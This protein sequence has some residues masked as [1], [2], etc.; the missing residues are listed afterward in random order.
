[1]IVDF[2]LSNFRSI[3][4]PMTLSMCATNIK[5]HEKNVIH[6]KREPKLGMLRSSVL[7]GPNASGKSNLIKALDV[8][9][10]FV[11]ESTDLKLDQKIPY[12]QPF[13][14]DKKWRGKP[15]DFEI[16]FIGYDGIRYRYSITF[17]NIEV[18][19]E[20]LVFFPKG[21]EANLFLRQKN[22]EIKFGDYF[23]GPKKSIEK[24]LLKN[25]LFLSKAAN[26]NNDQMKHIYTYF[27]DSLII[28]R[29]HHVPSVFPCFTTEACV[30][31]ESS[32]SL[33]MIGKF[34]KIADTGIEFME[35]DTES[36]S[37]DKLKLP[38]SMPEELKKAIILSFEN[39]PKMHHILFD[40]SQNSGTIGF[41]LDEESDGT[42]KLYRLSGEILYSL[43]NGLVLIIDELGSSLHPHM[44]RSIIELFNDPSI[45]FNNAQLIFASHD[46]TLLNPDIFRRDQIWMTEKNEFGATSLYSLVE[47]DPKKVRANI[48]FDK[49]YLSGRFGALPVIGELGEWIA[50][51]QKKANIQEKS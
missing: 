6:T 33:E 42:V 47:F 21:Q 40:G 35:F 25:N 2:T 39:R 29:P 20:S 22:T 24:Q 41:D 36:F 23:Q 45:N 8:L 1:M 16:E 38:D 17:N 12:Y 15:S 50:N 11:V 46:A 32:I 48:P 49:W 30:D 19:N 27:R 26:S 43:L 44:A 28:S 9:Q 5:D 51:A 18:L 14:L 31:D 4:E 10:D 3:K 34:L 7:Y 37:E 13:K